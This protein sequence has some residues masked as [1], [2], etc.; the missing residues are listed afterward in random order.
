MICKTLRPVTLPVGAVLSSPSLNSSKK[1]KKG[2]SLWPFS[3]LLLLAPSDHRDLFALPHR[4][5]PVD[6]HPTS[7]EGESSEVSDLK[8]LPTRKQIRPFSRTGMSIGQRCQ[9]FAR[10][11]APR[12]FHTVC[13]PDFSAVSCDPAFG[14]ELS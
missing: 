1:S 5:C 2:D 12:T 7:G 8:N 14:E 4:R 6:Q 9:V 11:H 3:P 13:S 10:L